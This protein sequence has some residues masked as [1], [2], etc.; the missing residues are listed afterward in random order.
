MGG[1]I[2]RKRPAPCEAINDRSGDVVTLFRVVKY[3]PEALL[4]E[5]RLQLVSRAEF[6]RLLAV[7]ADTLTDIQRAV[8]FLTLQRLVYGG[9]PGATS[10]PA[11]RQRG[12]NLSAADLRA[13]VEVVHDRLA[14]VTIENLEYGG[15]HSPLR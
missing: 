8:R 14:R 5:M 2:L 3:H 15:G 12:E 11:R 9:K 10:F 4:S 6:D 13:V 1:L 7:P